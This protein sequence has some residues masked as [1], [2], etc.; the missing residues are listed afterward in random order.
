[1]II[2]TVTGATRLSLL[3]FN[4]GYFGDYEF[5]YFFKGVYSFINF[6]KYSKP[7]IVTKFVSFFFNWKIDDMFTRL[8][9]LFSLLLLILL[10]YIVYIQ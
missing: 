5:L 3:F 9:L 8:I 7:L 6:H 2:F 4:V 10:S 1:M